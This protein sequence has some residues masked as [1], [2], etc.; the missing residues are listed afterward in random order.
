MAY[1]EVRYS[2]LLLF[3]L[4]IIRHIQLKA[5]LSFNEALGWKYAVSQLYITVV[6]GYLCY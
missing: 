4:V 5:F 6:I 2:L 3:T 1:I